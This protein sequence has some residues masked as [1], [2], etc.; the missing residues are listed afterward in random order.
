MITSGSGPEEVQCR[1]CGYSASYDM[2]IL[3]NTLERPDLL[4]Q[5]REGTIRKFACRRCGREFWI[6]NP[7]FVYNPGGFPHA[8]V[9]TPDSYRNAFPALASFFRDWAG[10]D[11]PPGETVLWMPHTIMVI[12]F[13]QDIRTDMAVYTVRPGDDAPQAQVYFDFLEQARQ[14]ERAG[15]R[16]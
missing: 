7:L 3:V 13:N 14:A 16:H 10:E 11:W 5:I 6:M 1:Y 12:A 15:G 4:R 2:W 8:V 9:I